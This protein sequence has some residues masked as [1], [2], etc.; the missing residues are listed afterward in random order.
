MYSHEIDQGAAGGGDSDFPQNPACPSC[1]RASGDFDVRH[2]FTANSVYELP[3]GKGRAFLQ[4]PGVASAV[5]GGWS[6]TGIGT[7]RTALPVNVTIDRSSTSVA[8]GYTTNQRPNIV[9]GVSLIPAGGRTVQQWINPDAF[10]PVIGGGYGDASRNIARGPALWQVDLGLA[11]RIAL[12]EL[13]TLT[14]RS[15]FFNVFNRAQ[16]GLPLADIS[17]LSNFGQIIGT[18]NLGPVG[19]GTPRQIQFLLR[20]DF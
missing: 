18:V 17:S 8:T 12:T 13:A 9:P 5:L 6:L 20:V 19:T 2:V 15:E 4:G 14:F 3:V 7:A 16:Y 1:E 11:K 10:S